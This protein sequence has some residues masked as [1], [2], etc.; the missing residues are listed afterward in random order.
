MTLSVTPF[1]STYIMDTL[2]DVISSHLVNLSLGMTW[3]DVHVAI[4]TVTHPD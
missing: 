3:L 2:K 4:S 1:D